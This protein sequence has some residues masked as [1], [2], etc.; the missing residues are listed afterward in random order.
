MTT[1]T[2]ELNIEVAEAIREGNMRIE[3]RKNEIDQAAEQ[4]RAEQDAEWLAEWQPLI[5]AIKDSIPP[6]AHQF[7][8]HPIISP[9]YYN[10]HT[11][12][13]RAA[14]IEIPDTA[15]IFAYGET[16][17][18]VRFRPARYAVSDDDETWDVIMLGGSPLS[19]WERENL[20]NDFHMAL[21]AA[22]AE[23]KRLPELRAEAERRNAERRN[24]ERRDAPKEHK[25]DWLLAAHAACLVDQHQ[26][27]IAYALTG[28]LDQLRAW[29]TPLYGG[30]QHAIQTFDNS[31]GQL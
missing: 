3:I 14:M 6:W 5:D 8:T 23:H 19:R 4:Q 18:P 7:L 24:A 25:T 29:S 31:R 30:S 15:T 2:D 21:A 13:V 17:S 28:I 1:W 9:D 12:H 26:A 16:K 27:A 22:A 20:T 10:D 11:L